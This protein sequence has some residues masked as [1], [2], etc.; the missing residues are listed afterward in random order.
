MVEVVGIPFSLVLLMIGRWKMLRVFGANR[1]K[2]VTEG[3]EN[4]VRWMGA[5]D[6]MFS[7]KFMYSVLQQRFVGSFPWK[8]IWK[9]CVQPKV[10]FFA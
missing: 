4:T 10:Y 3:V 8:C 1:E 7:V 9:N 6:G 5:K 2:R